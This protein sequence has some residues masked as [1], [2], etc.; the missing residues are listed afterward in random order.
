MAKQTKSQKTSTTTIKEVVNEVSIGFAGNSVNVKSSKEDLKTVCKTADWILEKI[1]KGL[2]G[3]NSD[4]E[5]RKRKLGL[6]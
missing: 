4:L 3:D 1:L 2:V 5:E 6:G